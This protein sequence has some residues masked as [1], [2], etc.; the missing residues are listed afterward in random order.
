MKDEINNYGFAE[1]YI[2]PTTPEQDDLVREWFMSEASVRY[3]LFGHECADVVEQ[4]LQAGGIQ[5][6]GI[7]SF[8]PNPL[9][10]LIQ[11]NN[12]GELITR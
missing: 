4:S 1:A 10:K 5:A 9:F 7:L 12:T 6:E 2:L 8:L 11:K 3:G